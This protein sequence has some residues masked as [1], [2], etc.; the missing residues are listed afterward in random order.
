MPDVERL[1]QSAEDGIDDDSGA[2]MDIAPTTIRRSFSSDELCL[3]IRAIE[4]G[5]SFHVPKFDYINEN[6]KFENPTKESEELSNGYD[7]ETAAPFYGLETVHEDAGVLETNHSTNN[8][9]QCTNGNGGSPKSSAVSS[10][11]LRGHARHSSYDVGPSLLSVG[12]GNGRISTPTSYGNNLPQRTS[13]FTKQDAASLSSSYSISS[14]SYYSDSHTSIEDENSSKRSSLD[15]RSQA[16][17]DIRDYESDA[18]GKSRFGAILSK[19]FLS[20]IRA[21]EAEKQ[22]RSTSGLILVDRPG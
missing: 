22:I 20:W 9:N 4:I 13:S 12:C 14:L 8:S 2:E 3:K 11:H 15:R 7:S 5:E 1:F 10:P 17:Y 19:G 16:S 6:S 18:S 21:K